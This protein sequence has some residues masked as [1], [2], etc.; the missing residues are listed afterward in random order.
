MPNPAVERTRRF[1]R[2]SIKP[3]WRRAAHLVR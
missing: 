2:S 3:P 1:G